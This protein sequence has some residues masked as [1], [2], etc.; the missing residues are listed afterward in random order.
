MTTT[1]TRPEQAPPRPATRHQGR[2]DR[3]LWLMAPGLFMITLIIGIPFL[4]AL[5]ISLL[6]LDQYSL[7]DIFGAP[8]AG[9]AN[10][11]EALQSGGLGNSILVSVAFAL[12]TTVIA[13]PLGV[14]AA[15]T[16]HDPFRGRGLL[17]SLYLLPYVIP[18]FVG[19][20]LWKYILQ[21]EG[22]LNTILGVFGIDGGSWLIGDRAFGSLVL[23][24]VWASFS[25]V[26]LLALAGLQTIPAER[27]DAVQVDGADWRQKLR[28]V[29]LPGIRG[30]LLL[31]LILSTIHHFNNFTLPFVLFGSPAPSSV[32]V[33][34][35]NI[36]STSF[37]VFRFG[38]G[39]AMAV[40]A[41]LVVLVPAIIY[42]RATK[43]EAGTG[44]E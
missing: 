14:L 44:D 6:E 13:A 10:F 21:P 42:L 12:I 8:Y 24:D 4:I 23:V 37:E 16:A 2:R 11:L 5:W 34:P 39:S 33:L 41:L 15:L 30:P 7:K 20:V 38:L 31:A 1:T 36:Y 19:A 18:N 43:L 29:V 32:N 26:Y 3:P 40:V 17:R 35:I 28:H 9:L 25:F 27:Y 22:P